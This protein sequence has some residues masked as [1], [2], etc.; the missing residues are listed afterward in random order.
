MYNTWLRK[1]CHYC[2]WYNLPKTN[3]QTIESIYKPLEQSREFRT[4]AR[5]VNI[6]K[7]S[8][9]KKLY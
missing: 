4:I 2:R 9:L 3:K 5:Y 6:Q 7:I 1:R 8:T